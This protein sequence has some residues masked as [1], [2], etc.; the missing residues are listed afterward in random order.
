MTILS[1]V[2]NRV[3]TIV[4]FALALCAFEAKA[5]LT[6]QGYS[7]ATAGM[8]DRFLNDPSFIGAGNNWSGV[9]H[10]INTVTN[11]DIGSWGTM[12]SPSYFISANHFSPSV[13]GANA[14]RFYYTN[15]T[16]GGFEDHSFTAIGAIAG[17]DLWLGKLN[18]P[19]SSNVAKYP[20]VSVPDNASYG[21]LP[22]TVVGLSS[23][24]PG[25]ATSFRLGT[26]N[27]DVQ[28]SLDHGAPVVQVNAEGTTG[29]TYTFD[30]TA[31]AGASEALLESGDSGAPNFYKLN[32]NMPAVIGINWYNNESPPYSGSTAVPKY[33]TELQALM[34]EPLTI[35]KDSA[36]LGDYSLDGQLTASDVQAMLVALTDL[37]GYKSLHGITQDY[38]L[39]IGDLN[40]DLQITNADLQP[41][42][43]LL[44]GAGGIAT[45]PEP[46]SALLLALGG[47]ACALKVAIRSRRT[48][49]SRL[50]PRIL[51][52]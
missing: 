23:P 27:I 22:I 11:A 39:Q 25:N 19:V 10:G 9:G 43:G 20:I 49:N 17:S 36:V 48:K 51:A 18:T 52:E 26:N 2:R 44:S 13:V 8:Y 40:H 24:F 3:G 34:T 29:Y 16:S 38:L 7:P 42:L 37:E 5:A 12:I 31:G 1:R 46:A 21:G 41:L 6:V 4:A 50:R 15:S 28:N 47:L 14:L 45:V 33:L 30:Y 35:V 32:G